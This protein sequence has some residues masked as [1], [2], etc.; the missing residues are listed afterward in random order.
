MPNIR[1]EFD[2]PQGVLGP[3]DSY[4]Q[5]QRFAV[6][7]QKHVDLRVFEH[8]PTTTRA[9]MLHFNQFTMTDLSGGTRTLADLE[10]N[11]AIRPGENWTIGTVDKQ[12]DR[13]N[14]K[15]ISITCAANTT[16][17]TASVVPKVAA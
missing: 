14:W 3:Y 6:P 7:R 13:N 1:E 11:V 10:S 15:G 2:N 8:A 16:T 4:N 9:I 12:A 17:V 5:T